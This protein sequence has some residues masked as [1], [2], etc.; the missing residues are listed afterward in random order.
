MNRVWFLIVLLGGLV[1]LGIVA[2]CTGT[3]D[4]D[5]D[6][7]SSDFDFGDCGISA[8][9]LQK[10]DFQFSL[11]DCYL[12][13]D[14]WYDL[15]LTSADV[16]VSAVYL[17]GTP[18]VWKA[19]DRLLFQGTFDFAAAVPF[20]V[21]EFE[22]DLNTDGPQDTSSCGD[23]EFTAVQGSFEILYDILEIE[24]SSSAGGE[25]SISFYLASAAADE[26][27]SSNY[28]TCPIHFE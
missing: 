13:Y 20:D 14:A 21:I 27:V 10:A 9:G 8:E 19:G 7:N 17:S 22:L 3:G 1:A 4:D 23:N 2:A 28:F 6:D 15:K 24:G 26:S 5:D 16:T 18:D 25:I 11:D 12:E